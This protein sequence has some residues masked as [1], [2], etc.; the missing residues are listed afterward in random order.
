M[1]DS[2]DRVFSH[3]LNTVNKIPIGAEKPPAKLRLKLYGLY[4][5]S[6]EGDVDGIMQRPSGRDASAHQAREKW[7]AW[8][9][10][11]GLS[12]TEA[13]RRYITTLISTMR[14]YANSSPDSRALVDE[15][16]FVWDQVKANA[17]SS[18]SSSPTH[19]GAGLGIGVGVGSGSGLGLSRSQSMDPAQQSLPRSD[20]SHSHSLPPAQPIFKFADRSK[21]RLSGLGVN[22]TSNVA[23]TR[24]STDMRHLTGSPL[25]H[26]VIDDSSDDDSAGGD[27]F[28]DAPDSQIAEPPPN[29]A[30]LDPHGK[31][32]APR[33]ADEQTSAAADPDAPKKRT[34]ADDTKWRRRVSTALIRLTAEVA[35]LREQLEARRLW[36]RTRRGTFLNL[37][38]TLISSV[39]KHVAFD[40]IILLLLLLWMRRKKD[41]RLEG[42]MRVLLG[43]AVAQ[44]QRVGTDL[45]RGVNKVGKALVVA[46]A[47]SKK[48]GSTALGN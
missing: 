44:V 31:R 6:M 13:K 33:A 41:G 11:A 19:H 15:L 3:A 5:Q 2:V 28:V 26:S 35:A 45:Q 23:G 39:L 1:S 18:S 47:S 12:R 16:E 8:K 9:S 37:T 32:A 24:T 34:R 43:D 10:C 38:W 42:A 20:P 7:D 27:E 40:A 17:S 29:P 48:G 36:T 21:K 22:S 4:K 46:G 14:Q 30:T 25:S